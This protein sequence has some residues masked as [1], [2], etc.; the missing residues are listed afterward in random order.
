MPNKINVKYVCGPPG[1]ASSV[2]KYSLCNNLSVETQVRF[3]TQDFSDVKNNFSH[4]GLTPIF[5]KI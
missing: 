3:S 1:P 4:K 2:E 5:E